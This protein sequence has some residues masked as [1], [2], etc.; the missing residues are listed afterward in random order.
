M[1]KCYNCEEELTKE[2]RSN[3]H[4]ILN[5]CGGKLSSEDLLCKT[6]NNNFG[7][8][9]DA[10]LARQTSILSNLLHINRDRSNPPAIKG[11]VSS[12]GEDIFIPFDGE[13]RKAK[14]IIIDRRE[15][16]QVRLTI[17][18]RDMKEFKQ[19]AKGLKKKYPGLPLEDLIQSAKH[20]QGYLNDSVVLGEN[21]GGDDAFKAVT[22]AAVN[23]FI[24]KGG[25]RNYIV[26][27]L[28]YLRNQVIIDVARLH[29]IPLSIYKFEEKEVS[30]IIKL[31]GNPDEAILYCY[32]EYFNAQTYIVW[33]S[34]NYDGPAIDETYI[35]DVIGCRELEKPIMITYNKAELESIFNENTE[36]PFSLIKD[37]YSRVIA[38]A[39]KRQDSQHIEMLS[40]QVVDEAFKDI[41]EGDNIQDVEIFLKKLSGIAAHKFTPFIIHKQK[42]QQ[43]LQENHRPDNSSQ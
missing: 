43:S 2:N 10:M 5:A 26:H 35:Y 27:L 11:K 18:A 15:G 33:L 13:L 24:H 23:Y 1:S 42:G 8:T 28:P 7:S 38:I 41:P 4:I 39:K 6:C 19:I 14:P 30:H 9:Y 31:I 21:I 29:F 40:Q 25:Y 22:K 3:E 12:T 16:D 37:R 34:K 32:I 20:Y 36:R 17:E